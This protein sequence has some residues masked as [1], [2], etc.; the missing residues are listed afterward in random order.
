M[1]HVVLNELL[2]NIYKDELDLVDEKAFDA[3]M[4]FSML[5]YRNIHWVL[6]KGE[7]SW[8]DDVRTNNKKESLKEIIIK[9][10]DSAVKQ[11]EN[12]VG[13]NP[14]VWSWGSLQPLTHPHPLGKV[15]FLDLLFGFNVGPYKAGGS[16]MTVNK[17]EYEI[18]EGF[19]QSV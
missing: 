8:I 13:V 12:E 3:L 1:F 14:P 15:K 2:N 16:T 9:S 17:G 7:S 19:D 6:S 5:P 4:H 11:I 18:L 10:F